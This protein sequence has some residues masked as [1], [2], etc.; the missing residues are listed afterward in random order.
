M[1]N[2]VVDREERLGSLCPHSEAIVLSVWECATSR[3]ERG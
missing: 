3:L 2:V 1:E